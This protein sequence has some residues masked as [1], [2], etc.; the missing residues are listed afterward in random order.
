M[1][2]LEYMN[3]ADLESYL[4]WSVKNYADEKVAAGAWSQ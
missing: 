4:E 3:K 2:A 1:I